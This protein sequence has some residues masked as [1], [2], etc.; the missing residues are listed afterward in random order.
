MSDGVL[1][2]AKSTGSRALGRDNE[3]AKGNFACGSIVLESIKLC[4]AF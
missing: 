2:R 3:Q 1:Q 4:E